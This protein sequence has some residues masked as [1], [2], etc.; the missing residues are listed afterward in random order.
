MIAKVAVVFHDVNVAHSSHQYVATGMPTKAALKVNIAK[1]YTCYS[2]STIFTISEY[3]SI[4]QLEVTHS[5]VT[6]IVD[7]QATNNLPGT[8]QLTN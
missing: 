6:N 7:H 8:I 1:T 2:H 5:P 3:L 4:S